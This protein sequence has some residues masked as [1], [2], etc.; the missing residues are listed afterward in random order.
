MTSG[1]GHVK[2]RT[3]KST[4]PA[5]KRQR[6]TGQGVYL[7]TI[8]TLHTRALVHYEGNEQAEKRKAQNIRP[9]I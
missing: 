3:R 8:S 7:S 6:G 5:A 9:I 2:R 4:I 1:T